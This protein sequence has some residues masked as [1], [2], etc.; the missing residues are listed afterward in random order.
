M[1][2]IVR[3]ATVCPIA[4]SIP[5]LPGPRIDPAALRPVRSGWSRPFFATPR[6]SIR[7]PRS[8]RGEGERDGSNA[9]GAQAAGVV[10]G[11]SSVNVANSSASE[12]PNVGSDL[13]DVDERDVLLAPLDR[14]DVGAVQTAKVS[15]L[16]LGPATFAA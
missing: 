6:K 1:S 15:E 14:S 5:R 9:V 12:T 16:F 3:N 7:S 4:S 8:G 2:M 13:L 11:W 10:D